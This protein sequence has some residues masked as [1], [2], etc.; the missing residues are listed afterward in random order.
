[1]EA[2]G[3]HHLLGWRRE[4]S[5]PPVWDLDGGFRATRLRHEF[6]SEEVSMKLLIQKPSATGLPTCILCGETLKQSYGRRN[7]FFCRTACANEWAIAFAEG[8]VERIVLPD[9]H[10]VPDSL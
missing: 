1:V 9:D 5:L 3:V 6:N 10:A 4:R 7:R 8:L 2:V